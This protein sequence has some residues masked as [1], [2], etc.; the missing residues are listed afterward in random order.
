[1]KTLIDCGLSR[2]SF[3]AAAAGLAL[4]CGSVA[5]AAHADEPASDGQVPPKWD[6]ALPEAWDREAEM[7]VLGTGIAGCCTAIEGYELGLDVLVV[8]ACGDITDCS[9]TLSGGWVCGCNTSLQ[10]EEGI[11]DSVETF[12]KDVRRDGGDFGD[13]DVIRAWAEI[14]GETI[15]WL[16]DLGCDV[17]ERT[18]DAA[19]S[20]GSN[21]H[22]VAR[23]YMTNPTG[24]GLGWMV[25]LQGAIEDYGIEVIYNTPA[26]KIFRDASGQVVGVQATPKDGGPAINVRATKGVV[27]ATGGLGTNSDLWG[28]YSPTIKTIASEA[29]A[30]LSGAPEDVDG[31]GIELMAD[32]DAYIYP[33]IANYGGGGIEVAPGEPANAILL[34]YVWPGSLIEVNANG[35]RFNDET[36]FS[37]YFSEKP[38]RD[39]PGMWHVVVFDET[40]RLSSEGQTYAQPILDSC[41]ENGI[42]ATV[43]GADSIEELAGHFGMDP[44]VLAATVEDFNARVD[45]QEPDEF[46]RASFGGKIE[47]PPFWGIA[48]DI[49]TATSKGGAKINPAGQVIDPDEQPIP[50]LYAAGECAFFSI[51]GN[52]QEHI[53]GG[54][55]GSAASFGRICARSIAAL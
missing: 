37:V 26:T 44:A 25:G 5:G 23:D 11:E 14:S 18:Y 51:H 19:T 21:S 55:N 30:I 50:G 10:E 39:Q 33:T 24:N 40:A 41:A 43:C 8:T 47:T 9:C 7:V 52:G 13:P 3:T 20:A 15:D 12:V 28:K 1:M 54:C 49:V 22:S 46:G 31:S 38:Y 35:E 36:S 29:R 45:S 17:V 32:V 42:D 16:W 48:Q 27:V 34:P 6:S 4:A 2:R 53:V